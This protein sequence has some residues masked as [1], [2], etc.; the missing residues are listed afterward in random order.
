MFDCFNSLTHYINFCFHFN[1]VAYSLSN[2]DQDIF[3]GYIVRLSLKPGNGQ[4]DHCF[5][6]FVQNNL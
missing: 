1:Y 5:L 2:E 3:I 4:I 6:D